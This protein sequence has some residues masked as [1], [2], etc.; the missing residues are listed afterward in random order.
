[1]NIFMTELNNI[2]NKKT[3]YKFFQIKV[4]KRCQLQSVD[5]AGLTPAVC[6][7]CGY[8]EYPHTE[9]ISIGKCNIGKWWYPKW[10]YIG[11]DIKSQQWVDKFIYTKK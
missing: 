6:K 3:K 10:K 9:P 7:N 2:L 11:A 1:M 8:N 4:C 5:W